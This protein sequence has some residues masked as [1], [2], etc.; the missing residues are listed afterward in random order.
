[1]R[2]LQIKRAKSLPPCGGSGLKCRS[3]AVYSC[4]DLSPSMRREWIEI[5]FLDLAFRN[6]HGLPPCGG[7]GLKYDEA[8]IDCP[9]ERGLPP[10]GGS[11]LK[12]QEL[13]TKSRQRR[14]PSMRREWIEIRP[15]R[16]RKMHR[17]RLPPCG[18][19]GLKCPPLVF[20]QPRTSV[21]LHA[22]GVD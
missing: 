3:D 17:R 2:H 16:R 15:M 11:G 8:V 6:C 14:S 9:E 12:L 1:M 5:Q 4:P 20:S 21:S 13:D 7:S 10:C 22:E 19:S 18:G